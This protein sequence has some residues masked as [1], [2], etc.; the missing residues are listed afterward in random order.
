MLAHHQSTQ[1]TTDERWVSHTRDVLSEF[2]AM[3]SGLDEAE[4]REREYALTGT[5]GLLVAFERDGALVDRHL[6]SVRALV[7]DNP[8]TQ[9]RVDGLI[10][11]TEQ[12]MAV[13]RKL[14]D[15][16]ERGGLEA[17][18][19]AAMVRAVAS[20]ISSVRDT[21]R[22]IE[23]DERRLLAV[24]QETLARSTRYTM[25][26]IRGLGVV[27]LVMLAVAFLTAHRARD[28]QAVAERDALKANAELRLH[29]DELVRR[30]RESAGLQQLNAALQLCITPSEAYAAV[31]QILPTVLGPSS[32]GGALAVLR[33]S[34]HVERVATWGDQS[35]SDRTEGMSPEDC[36]AL[37]SGRP[38]AVQPGAPGLRCR[39][40]ECDHYLCLPLAAHGETL[41]VLHVFFPASEQGVDQRAVV[42]QLDTDESLGLLQR[43]SEQIAITLANLALR[44][45][46]EQQSVRDALTGTFNRRYFEESLE[47]ELARERRR[48]R[49]LALVLVD[50]DHFKSVNDEH[51]HEAGDDALR[52]IAERLQRSARASD[53]VC[54]FGGE[55]FAIML[56]EISEEAAHRRATAIVEACRG[57]QLTVRGRTVGPITVSAGLARLAAGESGADMVRRAD[58]A[59]YAAKREGR[60]RLVDSTAAL[61]SAGREV[62]RS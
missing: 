26:A 14:I 60:D 39:H 59:L 55:E 50:I 62:T 13:M 28:R 21:V 44:E 3:V 32:S 57:S 30:S 2:D 61:S 27:S 1:R 15:A 7:A 49:G 47:R 24:R 46:L 51:G 23:G 38:Y 33:S 5:G 36:C 42:T 52:M 34:K 29:V 56:I 37:R 18:A 53:L 43:A 4:L 35:D 25:W 48:S 16:R 17:A 22:A 40:S 45:R 10:V 9:R 6:A 8:V 12:K 31:E 19:R 41:G 11:A 20:D 58:E 54:R